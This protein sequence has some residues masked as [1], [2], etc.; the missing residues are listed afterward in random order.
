MLVK[1]QGNVEV[2]TGGGA[3]SLHVAVPISGDRLFDGRTGPGGTQLLPAALDGV[4][5]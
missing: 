2:G 5:K 3:L 1:K 4:M